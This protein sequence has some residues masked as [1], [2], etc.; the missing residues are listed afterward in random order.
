MENK[1]NKEMNVSPKRTDFRGI[2][3]KESKEKIKNVTFS[4]FQKNKYDNNNF[5]KENVNNF[6][7]NSKDKKEDKNNNRNNNIIFEGSDFS[8][9]DEIN[10][11]II[12]SIKKANIVKLKNSGICIYEKDKST[13]SKL[14]N[15][16]KDKDFISVNNIE[17]KRNKLYI[18][19]FSFDK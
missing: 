2:N 13:I 5:I 12:K 19:T 9:H 8:F 4:K 1:N 10:G 7:I 15:A 17:N 11:N 6:I 18:F 16:F 3:E 14:N